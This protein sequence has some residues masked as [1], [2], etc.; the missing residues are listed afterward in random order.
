MQ[1]KARDISTRTKGPNGDYLIAKKSSC[2]GPLIPSHRIEGREEPNHH[3]CLKMLDDNGERFRIFAEQSSDVLLTL[4]LDL[5]FSYISPAVIRVLG[6]QPEDLIAR[7]VD[8]I[9]TPESSEAAH[10]VFRAA[11]DAI[12]PDGTCPE[13]LARVVEIECSRRDGD[14]IWAEVKLS[15]LLDPESRPAGVVGIARD[16][17]DRIEIER[18]RQE[19]FIQIEKNME[20]LATLNDHIRNPLQV[21]L[22][23]AE[24]EGKPF[25]D[26]II[27]QVC[28]IDT[29]INRLDRGY[30]ESEKIRD[31][32]R[33]HRPPL[34]GR[35]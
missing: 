24:L 28:E 12:E 23:L 21:I 32:L 9:L 3:P 34:I 8:F 30:L 29:I 22:G 33:K 19:A 35:N 6:Y 27:R 11:M 4:D 31:F 14:T 7:P 1:T 10:E 20:E 5:C 17:S 18:L 13:Y 2:E 15:F 25:S 16:I 26:D